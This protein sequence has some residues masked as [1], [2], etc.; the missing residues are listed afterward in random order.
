[1][2]RARPLGVNRGQALVDRSVHA[3]DRLLGRFEQ[4]RELVAFRRGVIGARLRLLPG[5]ARLRRDRYRAPSPAHRRRPAHRRV[6]VA[7]PRAASDTASR[8]LTGFRRQVERRAARLVELCASTLERRHRRAL[9]SRRSRA[10]EPRRRCRASISSCLQRRLSRPNRRP[11]ALSRD[12]GLE[13]AAP[14]ALAARSS[15]RSDPRPDAAA[16]WSVSSAGCA[17]RLGPARAREL[18][19]PPASCSAAS[20]VRSHHSDSARSFL[21]A[22]L[23][24]LCR[25]PAALLSRRALRRNRRRLLDRRRARVAARSTSA[26]R[27]ASSWRSASAAARL[28][29]SSARSGIGQ[30]AS[31]IEL[32]AGFDIGR[33][34][35]RAARAARRVTR[36]DRLTVSRR[37]ALALDAPAP[38]GRLAVDA[39]RRRRAPIAVLLSSSRSHGRLGTCLPLRIERRAEMLGFLRHRAAAPRS[40]SSASS[41]LAS[42]SL[43]LEGRLAPRRDRD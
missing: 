24:S 9:G 8:S 27:A 26:S 22:R 20:D 33:L 4:Q 25:A 39:R 18:L 17:V 34:G 29:L 37:G 21:A 11:V 36:G 42:W 12:I 30:R 2:Q 6:A 10:C 31:G 1:M 32:S 15:L 13:R 5:C 7:R 28:A 16:P 14:S 23:R 19:P 35:L 3:L 43:R 38:A 40:R 41:V